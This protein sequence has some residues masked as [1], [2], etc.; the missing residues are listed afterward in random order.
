MSNP[1]E[2]NKPT[3]PGE[4]KKATSSDPNKPKS[5]KRRRRRRKKPGGGERN[6]NKRDSKE[7]NSSTDGKTEKERSSSKSDRAPRSRSGNPRQG[8]SSRDRTS[9]RPS[10]DAPPR[11]AVSTEPKVKHEGF[12]PA[13]PIGDLVDD[14]F[15]WPHRELAPF[16]QKKIAE[17]VES[18]TNNWDT[19]YEVVGIR[20]HQSGRLYI[21]EALKQF[22]VGAYVVVAT[23]KSEW[24]G[25]VCI[26]TQ[27]KALR[28]RPQFR[29]TRVASN[30]EYEAQHVTT[31]DDRDLLEEVRTIVKR[32]RLAM[33]V[34]R[35]SKSVDQKTAEIHFTS[36]QRV[37][38]RGVV[39][40]IARVVGCRVEMKQ[41]GVRDRAKVIGGIGTCGETLCCTTWLPDFVPVSIKMAKDQGLVLNP[42]K[43]SGQCG[44]LKCCLVYEQDTYASLRKGLP[45]LGKRVISN[46]DD[47][48]GRVVE[49]DVLKQRIRVS[50]PGGESQVVQPSEIRPMF[51]SQNKSNK[52]P[53]SKPKPKSE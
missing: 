14:N 26:A 37:D 7:G 45:K 23:D 36:E 53:A 44:R 30:A 18:G 35:I 9:N 31:Q 33:N 22:P 13:N 20:Y 42:T 46:A 38:F 27:R 10:R 48:E 8:N 32:S 16:D 50:F 12:V 6:E 47:R 4:A 1:S 25:K 29:V 17:K 2:P 28:Q 41:T 51:A 11:A 39:G 40:D 5:Q 34:F 24:V 21:C 3:T 43:V 15:E 19:V 52:K 49:V